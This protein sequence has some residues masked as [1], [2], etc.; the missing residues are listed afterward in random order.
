[1][2]DDGEVCPSRSKALGNSFSLSSAEHIL[3]S[4]RT[5]S[6]REKA[7]FS[8]R[9]PVSR[10]RQPHPWPLTVLTPRLRTYL[11]PSVPQF[12]IATPRIPSP[13][14]SGG[15]LFSNPLP[16]NGHTRRLTPPSTVTVLGFPLLRL[17]PT[18]PG[19]P[20]S[21]SKRDTPQS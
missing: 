18:K 15:V 9:P 20:P 16:H 17:S 5:T 11:F 2:T 13:R 1:M 3:A 19:D 21:P 7:R 12:P 10:L 8:P 4:Q 14:P 6:N